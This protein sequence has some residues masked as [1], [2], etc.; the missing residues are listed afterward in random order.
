[1]KV[2][3]FSV[4]E[5]DVSFLIIFKKYIGKSWNTSLDT[6][7][8]YSPAENLY[9]FD[10]YWAFKQNIEFISAITQKISQSSSFSISV[11]FKGICKKHI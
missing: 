6:K 5:I 4:A 10:K 9:Y 3:Y 11:S 1:M 7:V 2:H 8:F